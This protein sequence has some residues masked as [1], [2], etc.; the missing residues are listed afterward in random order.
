MNLSLRKRMLA[1]LCGIFLLTAGCL[2]AVVFT[3]LGVYLQHDAQQQI[4]DIGNSKAERLEGFFYDTKVNLE[5]WTRLQVM[6]DIVVGDMDQR[7]ARSL[8]S[9]KRNYGLPGHLYVFDSSHR[10][11]STSL[12]HPPRPAMPERWKK[13]PHT[14]AGWFVDKHTDP[15]T[16]TKIIAFCHDL[17][18]SFGNG[19]SRMLGTIVLTYPW[20]YIDNILQSSEGTFHILIDR[21]GQ[22][23]F[24]DPLF[25]T[26]R[27]LENLRLLQNTGLTVGI[28]K[29]Q[30]TYRKILIPY[31]SILDHWTLYTLIDHQVIEAP[32]RELLA[33]LLGASILLLIPIG[34]TIL[35][36]SKLM[37]HPLRHLTQ[38]ITEI[39]T[40]QDLARRAPVSS[41]DEIGQLASSFN[42][43]VSKLEETLRSKTRLANKLANINKVLEK[44]VEERTQELAWQANHD[45]L[46]GLPNRTLLTDR[47]EQTIQST[48]RKDEPPKLAVLFMDL[49][50]FK[51]INDTYGHEAGDYLLMEIANR[52]KEILR[53][54]DTI[55]RLGGDEF[56]IL[57]AGLDGLED[58]DDP[59]QRM[60]EAVSSPVSIGET[61]VT[62][63]ASIG[64]TLCPDDPGD[65]DT[66]LRHA[67]Q[68]M[69]EAKRAGRNQFH[70]FNPDSEQRLRTHHKARDLLSTALRE[71]RLVLHYQPQIHME[72]G[73]VVGV[74]ALLR[75]YDQEGGLHPP[76]PE[77]SLIENTDCIVQIGEWVM[78]TALEQITL[79]QKTEILIPV[80]INL[81][82]HHIQQHEFLD[83]LQKIL[84]AHPMKHWKFLQIEIVE[85]A[86]LG[87]M[88]QARHVIDQCR[89]WGIR[90]ALDDF[91][92]GYSS[93]SYLKQLETDA[94]KI[95]RSFVL[96]ILEDEGDAALVKSIIEMS[97]IF[98]RRVIAEGVETDPHCQMLLNMGC[99]I[100]QGYGLASPMDI[101]EFEYWYWQRIEQN[102]TA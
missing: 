102:V 26:P 82:A 92:T 3:Y 46:T 67:D 90:F 4:R 19:G 6:E 34:F 73:R 21:R 1:A 8:N 76:Q 81:S 65:A 11:I 63:G 72:T 39:A 27:L 52:L 16:Q 74:E 91:G 61:T 83:R 93:L 78:Q 54:I 77:L 75:W 45:P 51:H 59:L 60:M 47:L 22:P 84:S 23:I 40:T 20:P 100:G 48:Q 56:V 68:A 71:K 30:V 66:L 98:G 80:S 58:L 14:V 85:S 18:A 89:N 29:F 57:L 53:D 69:Y 43:M 5:A 28:K 44:K 70:L 49:D 64:I 101:E 2:I 99:E 35:T 10:L 95:D 42:V 25:S 62:V 41:N 97:R 79:W 13:P 50:G 37:V 32:Q 12:K 55:A 36:F 38:T 94:I 96:D 9:L 17:E 7:I 31:S 15:F 87:N 33:R 88:E 24:H 86:A